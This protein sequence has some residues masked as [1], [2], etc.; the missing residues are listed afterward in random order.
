M[1][2][3][4]LH[5]GFPKTATTTIQNFLANNDKAL[6]EKGWLYPK[7]GR[8]YVA[9]HT[10][11]NFFRPVLLDWIPKKDPSKV[12]ADLLAELEKSGCD[13][14]IMST[15]ALVSVPWIKKVRDYFDDFDVSVV[16]FLRR[17]DQWLESAYQEELKNGP[18]VHTK[19]E[20]LALREHA[21]DYLKKL[22]D[23]GNV[24]GNDHMHIT[25][26]EKGDEQQPVE[27]QFLESIGA[28]F[29]EEFTPPQ[30]QNSRLNRDCLAFFTMMK[31][32]R[33]IGPRL[34][35]Y[36]DILG[37]YS[38]KHP[39]PKEWKYFW[40]PQERSALL[41]KY[42]E[43]NA[44]VAKTFL[45]RSDGQ[46]FQGPP[47]SLDEAWEP[48]PGLTAEKA[49]EIGEYLA[50]GLYDKLHSSKKRPVGRRR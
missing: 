29:S 12:K 40:S 32:Q 22:T 42:E 33:R 2:K 4:Y 30:L 18:D 23:W 17:Q 31:E 46:L 21:L 36:K 44:E 48:Y 50:K 7:S 26:F 41:E 27:R 45:G 14:V 49:V 5:V 6:A 9:H 34:K 15:E 24:F 19:E 3:L 38:A 39:D 16:F 13:N 20:Y 10:L 28:P 1:P 43:A 35:L 11:G 25:V 8:Q 47:V 37:E